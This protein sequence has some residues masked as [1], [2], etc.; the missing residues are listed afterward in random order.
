MKGYIAYNLIFNWHNCVINVDQM[1]NFLSSLKLTQFFLQWERQL[2]WWWNNVH[3]FYTQ[4]DNFPDDFKSFNNLRKFY[5][6][7]G[8]FPDDLCLWTRDTI[9]IG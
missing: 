5:I 9:F 8:K 7:I 1:H 3:N 6:E 2:S 4:I